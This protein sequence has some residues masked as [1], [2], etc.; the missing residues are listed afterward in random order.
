MRV[1]R[2]DEHIQTHTH[3]RF[4]SL[5]GLI[6]NGQ[7]AIATSIRD[8]TICTDVCDVTSALRFNY[9]ALMWSSDDVA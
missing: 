6:N 4:A 8:I 5:N 3:A 2:L 9:N 7:P 1:F